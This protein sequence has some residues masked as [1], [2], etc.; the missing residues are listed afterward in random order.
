MVEL[1]T[2][3]ADL[4]D[5]IRKRAAQ[6]TEGMR[7]VAE[8]LTESDEDRSAHYELGCADG[9]EQFM[10]VIEYDFDQME[11]L[12]PDVRR[13]RL[14]ADIAAARE[15]ISTLE[16][17]LAEANEKLGDAESGQKITIGVGQELLLDTGSSVHPGCSQRGASRHESLLHEE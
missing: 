5:G 13:E 17:M 14:E 9:V 16:S 3:D 4:L 1:K 12:C 15:R 8:A 2:Y 7:S 11:A 6:Y 10:R